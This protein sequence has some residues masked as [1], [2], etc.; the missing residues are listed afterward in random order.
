MFVPPKMSSAMLVRD[1]SRAKG[2]ESPKKH[3]LDTPQIAYIVLPMHCAAQCCGLSNAR[4]RVANQFNQCA[5]A[6]LLF[7]F[8]LHFLVLSRMVV[9]TFPRLYISSLS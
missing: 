2:T 9:R 6:E 1:L 5:L 3:S 4:N 7:D 8:V